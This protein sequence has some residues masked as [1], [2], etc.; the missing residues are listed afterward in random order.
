MPADSALTPHSLELINSLP[1]WARED[2]D[3][4]ALMHCF[5]KETDRILEHARSVRD[6]AIPYRTGYPAWWLHILDVPEPPGSP[7]IADERAAVVAALR[8]AIP[9]PSG[10]TWQD[11]VTA[12]V[13]PGWTYVEDAATY[14]LTIEIPYPPDSDFFRN[15]TRLIRTFT[16]AHLDIVVNSSSIFRVDV[17][18]LD[19]DTLG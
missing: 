8:R 16:P 7:T 4:R 9:D 13:G 15:L 18:D 1:G 11:A 2:P 3:L 5:A 12:L 14:T 17:S 6:G 10:A 19:T